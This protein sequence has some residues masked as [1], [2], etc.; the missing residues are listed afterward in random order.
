MSIRAFSAMPLAA[1]LSALA[2]HP[3]VQA[4]SLGE[5]VVTANRGERPVTETLSDVTVIDSDT[6]ARAG[7]SSLPELLRSHGGIEISQNGAGAGLAGIFVRGTKTSQTLVLVDGVR[8]ENPTSGTANLEFLPLSAIDR[9]EIVR[10]PTSAL[11]GSGAI[12]GVIQVFT[13]RGSGPARPFVSAGIGN[14]GTAQLQAGVSGSAGEGQATRFSVA[15]ATERTGGFDSTV[16]SSSNYQQDLDGSSR[17]DATASLSH[18]FT[19]DWQVGA[20][21]L[22]GSG[23]SKYDDAYSTPD[24][25]RFEYRSAAL[26]A[27]VRG[28][29]STA[30]ETELRLGDTQIDYRYDAFSYAPRTGSQTIAWQNSLALPM[31]RLLFG[32]EHLHQRIEGD[33]LTTGPYAYLRD[34]RRTDSVFAGYEIGIDRHQLRL[35][36]RRDRIESVG[37]EPTGAIAWGYRLAPQW[38]LRASYASAFRAPT[39]D[40]L[41][42]PFGSNPDLR[43]ERSRGVELGIEHRSPTT[44][45]KATAF[46]SRIRDAIELDAMFM[47]QNL[48]SARVRGLTLEAR[49]RLGDWS[50]RASAT[51]QDPQGERFD[52]V[53]GAVVSGPL[54]RRA[55]R[56]ATAGVDW[57]PSSWRVGVEWV[58]Q[59][60]RYDS[61]RNPMGGYGILSASATY[62]LQKG[63]DLFARLENLGDRRYETAWGYA[64]P[65]RTVFVGL[66]YQPI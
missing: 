60:R 32:I 1:A 55:R 31:G 58:V 10:G 27:F 12:G 15:L 20:T 26:T 52:G 38:Q 11:Y 61:D 34:S 43:P 16:P 46:A 57:Q 51:A 49:H 47:P 39:F 41:Y 65:P 66:R 37:A 40:D 59:G 48:D 6:I 53:S 54:A 62:P 3:A 33:G 45:V 21:A 25:A 50:L 56:F 29:P 2:L 30:W 24:T 9:I 13:R 5:V 44:L 7:V 28:R 42:N 4:Q 23:R 17:R 35:Q 19:R 14:R 22:F 64:M 63:L 8:L 18:A 36:L